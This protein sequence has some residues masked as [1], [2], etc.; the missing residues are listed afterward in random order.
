M[1]T[2]QSQP[3]T[4]APTTTTT[5]TS[6]QTAIT[7]S[8]RAAEILRSALNSLVLAESPQSDAYSLGNSLWSD[9][10]NALKTGGDS[11]TLPIKQLTEKEQAVLQT[12]IEQKM[13][14]FRAKGQARNLACI[15]EV[16]N[17]ME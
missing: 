2:T 1:S 4:D 15:S 7:V 13:A 12:A 9:V 16:K 3:T 10:H 17:T 5:A 6:E 8:Q 14:D 11:I